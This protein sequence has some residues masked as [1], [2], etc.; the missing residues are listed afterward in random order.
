MLLS[1]DQSTKSR[2]EARRGW[3]CG[4]MLRACA[5]VALDPGFHVVFDEIL[6]R[7]HG[8]CAGLSAMP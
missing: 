7:C 8:F 2:V 5:L 6:G 4:R 3:A 1:P